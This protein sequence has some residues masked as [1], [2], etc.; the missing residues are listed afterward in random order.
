MPMLRAVDDRFPVTVTT[1]GG[2]ELSPPSSDS[3]STGVLRA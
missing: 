1:E 2:T 3:S